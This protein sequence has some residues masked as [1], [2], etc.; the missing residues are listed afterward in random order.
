[1]TTFRPS[2]SCSFQAR[3]SARSIAA[4]PISVLCTHTSQG[5]GCGWRSNSAY[6]RLF[7]VYPSQRSLPGSPGCGVYPLSKKMR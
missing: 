6:S 3:N 2:S 5:R 1:M 4:Q 7:A